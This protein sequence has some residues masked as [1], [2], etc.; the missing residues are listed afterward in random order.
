MDDDPKLLAAT[1]VTIKDGLKYAAI[2]ATFASL[3]LYKKRKLIMELLGDAD[4]I[5]GMEISPVEPVFVR[6]LCSGKKKM[7]TAEETHHLWTVWFIIKQYSRSGDYCDSD[8]ESGGYRVYPS[9]EP[10]Y[11]DEYTIDVYRQDPDC[12]MDRCE[13]GLI[14]GKLNDRDVVEYLPPKSDTSAI[15]YYYSL[16]YSIREKNRVTKDEFFNHLL[17]HTLPD[18]LIIRGR[19]Q[20]WTRNFIEDRS[21]LTTECLSKVGYS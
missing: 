15:K 9:L 20:D 19:D 6:W 4:I 12:D 14:Y 18:K 2:K 3:P 11:D 10:M 21:R 17:A 13:D 16:I 5:H 7:F 8:H 1:A